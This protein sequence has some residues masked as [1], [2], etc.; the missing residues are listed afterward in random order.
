MGKDSAARIEL[1]RSFHQVGTVNENVQ[2]IYI[3][4]LCKYILFKFTSRTLQCTLHGTYMFAS[5]WNHGR[6]S[7]DDH[8]TGHLHSNRTNVWSDKRN[9]AN[10]QSGGARGLELRI[11]VLGGR[12]SPCPYRGWTAGARRPIPWWTP[13]V[14]LKGGDI[15]AVHLTMLEVLWYSSWTHFTYSSGTPWS[16]GTHQMR[17]WG[18]RLN[19]FFRSR[20]AICTVLYFS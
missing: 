2:Y 13:T 10:V 17:S 11:A 8:F 19:V 5:N 7:C 1:G 9:M 6:I 4:Y 18:T 20:K 14:I 3:I 16:L 12:P 15:P